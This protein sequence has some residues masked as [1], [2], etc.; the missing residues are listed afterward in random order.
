M[1]DMNR[2]RWRNQKMM[3]ALDRARLADVECGDAVP[4]APGADGCEKGATFRHL[5]RWLR[6]RFS[7]PVTPYR[8]NLDMWDAR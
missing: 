5:W 3:A 2:L 4:V 7:R 6:K 8:D 1:T